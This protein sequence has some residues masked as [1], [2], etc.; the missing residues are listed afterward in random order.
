VPLRNSAPGMS[1]AYRSRPCPRQ[2]AT[3]RFRGATH[4][5]SGRARRDDRNF[6]PR[7]G[8]V[9]SGSP[10][11]GL[12]SVEQ[13]AGGSVVGRSVSHSR[14]S[15]PA[16]AVR[17]VSPQAMRMFILPGL[18]ALTRT[19]VPARSAASTRVTAFEARLGHAVPDVRGAYRGHRPEVAGDVD[20]PAIT[21]F[22][23]ARGRG[24]ATPPGADSVQHAPHS[25][26]R[27]DPACFSLF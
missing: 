4:V 12:A 14:D 17:S 9:V 22:D 13:S 11:Q 23:H 15:A 7:I 10:R 5:V 16:S 8:V 21:A 24:R 2:T 1:G 27:I 6:R 3:V 18:A 26:E 25:L 20:D 19:P